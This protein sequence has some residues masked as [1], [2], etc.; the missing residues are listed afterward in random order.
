[1]ARARRS[2]A[3]ARRRA[4]RSRSGWRRCSRPP[5][6]PTA[7]AQ[8]LQHALARAGAASGPA[9]A[10]RIARAAA[11]DRSRDRRG[12]GLARARFRRPHARRAPEPGEPARGGAAAQRGGARSRSARRSAVSRPIEAPVRS[13]RRAG[14][15]DA[16]LDARSRSGAARAVRAR[17]GSGVGDR[18]AA[19]GRS[20]SASGPR[21]P[22]RTPRSASPRR[23]RSRPASRTLD[24]I[25]AVPTEF[26]A[27][28][29]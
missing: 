3:R 17:S 22:L 19:R 2:R 9:L 12:G 15:P 20:R 1:M 7:A 5:D 25:L 8:A 21:A 24:A 10:T 29:L 6:Q 28:G 4:P 27:E 13:A 26:D 18:A 16:R 23:S 14:D 11:V